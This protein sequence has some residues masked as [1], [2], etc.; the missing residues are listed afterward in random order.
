MPSRKDNPE[1]VLA[2][3]HIDGANRD[4]ADLA[5]AVVDAQ[6]LK[7]GEQA[8]HRT[9]GGIGTIVGDELPVAG[10]PEI[11]LQGP[12]GHVDLCR[13]ESNLAAGLSPS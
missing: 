9:G 7:Q 2:G 4:A 3:T 12:T 6:F 8:I 11:E 13:S 5:T 10:E 1:D